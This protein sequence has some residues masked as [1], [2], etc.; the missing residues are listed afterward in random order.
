[1]QEYFEWLIN[2]RHKKKYQHL[3]LNATT[4]DII[5]VEIG[6]CIGMF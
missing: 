5:S 2:R 1:M 4:S 3:G 6:I